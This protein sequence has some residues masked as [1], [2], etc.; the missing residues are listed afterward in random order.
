MNAKTKPGKSRLGRGLNALFEEAG[1]VYG[2]D[3]ALPAEM[4]PRAKPQLLPIELLSPGPFQPRHDFDEA[5]LDELAKSI[6]AHGLLQPVLV[7]ADPLQPG[8]WTII[9]GERRWRAAQKARLHEIPVRVVELDNRQALEVAL[10]ENLQ[11]ADLGALEEAEGYR[12]L[13][14]EYHHTQE[15]LAETLGKS[16][17]HIA[18]MLR[19]LSLPEPVRQM[20][21][22]KDLSMSHA[23]ALLASPEHAAAAATEI[24]KRGLNV[25]QTEELMS[26]LKFGDERPEK[27]KVSAAAPRPARKDAD[28]LA[29]ERALTEH[30]GLKV[31]IDHRQGGES[32]SLRIDYASLDQLDDLMSR[33]MSR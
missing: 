18:N 30:L 5:A 6:E 7:R 15:Q 32:G 17:S 1:A 11:R 10:V 26:R 2:G 12:R 25:R 13:M 24:V 20:V 28:T 14:E 23:R 29:L 16:R 27:P 4:A 21:E 31:N 9:A 33:L 3:G 19:L 8:R 22:R